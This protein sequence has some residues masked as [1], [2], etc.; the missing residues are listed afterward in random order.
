MAAQS[1][2]ERLRVDVTVAGTGRANVDTG[3]P[4][5]DRLLVLLAEYARFD[6]VVALATGETSADA[7]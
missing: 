3:F 6:L 7:I 2:P 4:V 1:R 5:L